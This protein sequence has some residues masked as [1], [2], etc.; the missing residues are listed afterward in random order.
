M[1]APLNKQQVLTCIIVVAYVR[2]CIIIIFFPSSIRKLY[3]SVLNQYVLVLNNYNHGPIMYY[4]LMLMSP[5]LMYMFES[6]TI[7]E[8]LIFMI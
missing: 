2:I 1:T 5:R 3:L 6:G 4:V 7:P 8:Y